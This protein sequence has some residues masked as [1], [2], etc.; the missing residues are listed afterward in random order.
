MFLPL[1][2]RRQSL[3]K[4]VPSL[5]KDVRTRAIRASQRV[6]VHRHA[7]ERIGTLELSDTRFGNLHVTLT[8]SL[9]TPRGYRNLL[10]CVDRFSRWCSAFPIADITA[11]TLLIFLLY[12]VA[13]Y[14]TLSLVTI[15]REQYFDSAIY[16][17]LFESLGC[18][19]LRCWNVFTGWKQLLTIFNPVITSSA[20]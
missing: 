10:K 12:G 3:K 18:M 7:K 20:G 9:Q 17:L 13:V 5:T 4:M 19:R 2:P 14:S 11:E 6:K 8:S 1:L 15:K 16:R